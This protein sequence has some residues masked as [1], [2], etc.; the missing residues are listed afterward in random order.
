MLG[1]RV[2]TLE[3]FDLPDN[4]ILFKRTDTVTDLIVRKYTVTGVTAKEYFYVPK[5]SS[6][7]W[8]LE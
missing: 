1:Y 3:I 7:A 6:E 5:T 8:T 4:K 2:G